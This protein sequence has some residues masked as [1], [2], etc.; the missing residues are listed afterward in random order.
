MTLAVQ[1]PQTVAAMKSEEFI[2]SGTPLRRPERGAALHGS[3][4]E[5]GSPKRLGSLNPAQSQQ[6]I[7]SIPPPKDEI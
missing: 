6:M 1:A 7:P 2:C 4:A 5:G 3:A